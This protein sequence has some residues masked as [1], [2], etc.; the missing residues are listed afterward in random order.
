MVA[1]PKSVTPARIRSNFDVFSF[2]LDADDLA[3]LAALDRGHR[4]VKGL[5]W[6]REGEKWEDLWDNDF[7]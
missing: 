1:I 2:A 6:L 5:Q 4:L 7:L 3:R